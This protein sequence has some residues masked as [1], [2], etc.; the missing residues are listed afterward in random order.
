MGWAGGQRAFRGPYR[1]YPWGALSLSP[2]AERIWH[3]GLQVS[4]AEVVK[5]DPVPGL[6]G[7]LVVGVLWVWFS[8]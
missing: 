6:W 1:V 4:R 7:S 8:P 2:E 3:E 5:F